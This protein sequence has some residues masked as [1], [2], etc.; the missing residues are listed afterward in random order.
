[1]PDKR[2]LCG[3][4]KAPHV[5]QKMPRTASNKHP[6]SSSRSSKDLQQPAKHESHH[7]ILFLYLSNFFFQVLTLS[8]T[9]PLA[10][11]GYMLPL[12]QF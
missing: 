1:M 11:F 12:P 5:V 9:C 10:L 7:F 6:Q 8:F 3:L 2:V 4:D